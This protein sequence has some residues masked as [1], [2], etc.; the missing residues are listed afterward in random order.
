[1][2]RTYE[3][4]LSPTKSQEERLVYCLDASRSVYNWAL[5]DRR[6]LYQYGKCSTSFYD[7]CKW[8]VELKKERP[9]LCDVHVHILQTALKRVDLAFQAFFRRIR[10]GQKPGYP[11][12]KGKNYFKSFSFK[13]NENGFKLERKRLS[14][15]KVGRVRIRRHREIEGKIKSCTI[16][17]LADGWFAYIVTEVPDPPK[18]MLFKPVGVDMGLNCFAA[19]SDGGKAKNPRILK[20]ALADIKRQQRVLARREKKSG[21]RQD[22]KDVLGKMHLKVERCRKDFHYEVAGDLIA[23]F[24]PLFFEAL[25]IVEMIRKA[26]Q[27]KKEHKKYA[28]KSENILDAAW[29]KFLQRIRSKAR[30][31]GSVI[32]TV[33]PRGTS[34]RCSGC[35]AVVKKGLN[36]RIHS[37]PWCG[38]TIDRDLNAAINILLLGLM[39]LRE[40]G[41]EWIVLSAREQV[42]ALFSVN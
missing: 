5:E 9:W 4:K 13:E 15:S 30:N 41:T 34:Q 36:V 19:D 1:M 37:C 39:L 12:F 3:F 14:I 27:D 10:E 17:R 28:A 25:D 7:Q 2:N 22:A 42:G 8:L 18:N 35:C 23:R 31:A 20:K 32:M 6:D 11:R 16:K 38:L 21:R 26:T 33:D 29:G 24:N 40:E